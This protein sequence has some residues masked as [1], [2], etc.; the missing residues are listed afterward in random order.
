MPEFFLAIGVV[1]LIYFISRIADSIKERKKN[2]QSEEEGVQQEVF[3]PARK[4]EIPPPAGACKGGHQF[5]EAYAGETVHSTPYLPAHMKPCPTKRCRICGCREK[6]LPGPQDLPAGNIP[7][8]LKQKVLRYGKIQ[9][10]SQQELDRLIR[11][12]D[13]DLSYRIHAAEVITD[14]ALILGLLRESHMKDPKENDT[15][16]WTRL[17]WQLSVEPDSEPFKSVAADPAYPK[18]ARELV[19]T[20]ILDKDVLNRLAE[21]PDLADACKKQQPEAL[22]RDGHIWIVSDT[23]IVSHDSYR[24]N[25]P[26]WV[27]DTYRCSR[28]GKTKQGEMHCTF[29][30]P[31]ADDDDDDDDDRDDEY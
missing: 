23:K 8:E 1:V 13:E 25:S 15:A 10:M 22:C 28:C 17:I 30:S 9:N 7:K 24:M 27:V 11:N 26:Y 19:I 3:I 21:D 18:A 14:K 20:R 31:Y 6:P 2:R 5:E 16:V 4:F 29:R 12:P